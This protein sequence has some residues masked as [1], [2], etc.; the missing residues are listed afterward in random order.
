MLC[1]QSY[2]VKSPLNA[3]A[4]AWAE[5]NIARLPLLKEDLSAAW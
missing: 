5:L 2:N 4:A 1:Y 3:A